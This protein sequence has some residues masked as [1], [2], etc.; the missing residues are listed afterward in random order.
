MFSAQLGIANSVDADNTASLQCL[1]LQLAFELP[2]CQ[3]LLS[4]E[5][6]TAKFWM[7]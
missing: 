1:L 2:L 3:D 7:Y 5:I 6:F 4:F